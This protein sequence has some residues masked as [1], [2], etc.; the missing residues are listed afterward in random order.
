MRDPANGLVE[1]ILTFWAM[2]YKTRT[3]RVRHG[4]VMGGCMLCH[5]VGRK[6]GYAVGR[7]YLG[8]LEIDGLDKI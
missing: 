7:V 5:Y 1:H 4:T 3:F 2:Q 6:R 8:V